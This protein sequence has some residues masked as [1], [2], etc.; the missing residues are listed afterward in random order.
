[1]KDFSK[2]NFVPTEFSFKYRYLYLYTN[3][4][5]F[6]TALLINISN[7]LMSHIIQIR[8]IFGT[9]NIKIFNSITKRRKNEAHDP[10]RPVG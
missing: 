5:Q 3:K 6:D 2:S 7:L 1:M 4:I 9:V 10:Q 8:K